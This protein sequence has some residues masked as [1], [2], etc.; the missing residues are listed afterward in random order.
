MAI[1]FFLFVFWQNTEL[2]LFINLERKLWQLV[3]RIE[4]QILG[5]KKVNDFL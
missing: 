2:I 4:N 5:N 1:S 3:G